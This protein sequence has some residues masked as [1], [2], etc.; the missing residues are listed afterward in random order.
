MRKFFTLL[1]LLYGLAAHDQTPWVIDSHSRIRFHNGQM[2]EGGQMVALEITLKK[3]FKTYWRM[4][5]ETGLSPNFDFSGSKNLENAEVLFPVPTIFEEKEG[6]SLGYKESVILPILLKT[7]NTQNPIELNLTLNYGVC[8][9]LC[10]PVTQTIKFTPKPQF[11]GLITRAL[12]D[13]P[14]KKQLAFKI[15]PKTENTYFVETPEPFDK[16]LIEAEK[17]EIVLPLPIKT[18]PNG[19]HVTLKASQTKNYRVTLINANNSVE[20]PLILP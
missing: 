11:N 4:A 13:V 3:G 14:N 20:S 7:Q 12:L 1:S 2:Q 6:Y 15:T 9:T 19:F 8:D 10:L 5:G 18:T 16:M 17:Q